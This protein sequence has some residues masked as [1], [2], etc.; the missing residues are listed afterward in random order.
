MAKKK[1]NAA[2]YVGVDIGGTKL[3][4]VV[5]GS[6]G[7]VLGKARCKTGGKGFKKVLARVGDLVQDACL[8]AG[9]SPGKLRA[10]GVGA[11][12]PVLPDGTAVRLPTSAGRWCR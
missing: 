3:Y 5:T 8:D 7:K 6:R 1:R 9:A 12:S 4:A 2:R 11:P 10:V